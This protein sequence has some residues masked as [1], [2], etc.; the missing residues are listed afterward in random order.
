MS[1]ST[2]STSTMSTSTNQTQTTAAA[3]LNDRS[4]AAPLPSPHPPSPPSSIPTFSTCYVDNLTPYELN[5]LLTPPYT[6]TISIDAL[7][8][9]KE[10][11][12]HVKKGWPPRPQNAWVIFRKDFESW[13]R[14]QSPN[15][16][17]TVHEISKI[18]GTC[19][20][21]QSSTVKQYFTVLSKL[22]RQQHRAEFPDYIYQPRRI[23]RTKRINRPQCLYRMMSESAFMDYQHYYQEAVVSTC[24]Q[25][26]NEWVFDEQYYEIRIGEFEENL[27]YTG[28]DIGGLFTPPPSADLSSPDFPHQNH[29]TSH[30]N[31]M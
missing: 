2:M 14:S 25:S 15:T 31:F 4:D 26:K 19:W 27:L 1:S 9:P 20:R 6:L 12:S 21:R 13:L 23:K 24:T 10:R 3:L 11:K 30:P 16:F 8:R 22:A 7:L 17:F 18:A 5:L 28:S 29:Q